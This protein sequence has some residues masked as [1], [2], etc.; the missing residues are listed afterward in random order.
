LNELKRCADCDGEPTVTQPD[1]IYMSCGRCDA[2]VDVPH[3]SYEAACLYWN[4]I[5]TQKE[6]RES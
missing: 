6:E 3:L 5:Q 4:M 2:L 1:Y